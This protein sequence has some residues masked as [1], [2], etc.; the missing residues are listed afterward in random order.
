MS[1]VILT[2]S[3]SDLTPKLGGGICA[4]IIPLTYRL[5]GVDYQDKKEEGYDLSPFYQSIRDGV[6]CTTSAINMETFVNSF[7]K[8]LKN[9][10]DV[11]YIAFSSALSATCQNARIA[12][13][14]L[15]EKYPEQ[16][17]MVVDSLCVCLGLGYLIS[18]IGNRL[19]EFSDIGQIA[20]YIEEIKL[21]ICHWFTV[22]SLKYLERGGRVSHVSAALGTVLRIN[23]LMRTD[24]EGK[25][26][27]YDK[28]R[29]RKNAIAWLA[30]RFSDEYDV[31]CHGT[32]WIG[33]ADSLVDA[34]ALRDM[35][36]EKGASNVVISDIGPVIGAHSGPGTLALF[37]IAK[38]R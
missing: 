11:L 20:D 30:D 23:P 28:T 10:Q 19:G 8:Y 5:D 37:F 33:H 13:D 27:Y 15:R 6:T 2:D 24:D 25:L 22:D 32:A 16:K 38:G 21:K 34:A 4:E 12:A 18:L 3:A 35:L 7:E 9:G 29:G 17:V 36:I 1:Y 14:E 31:D 26:A